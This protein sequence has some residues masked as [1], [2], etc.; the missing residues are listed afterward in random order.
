MFDNLI[1]HWV[2]DNAHKV[3]GWICTHLWG[4][5]K[6]EQILAG[7]HID[8]A[9]AQLAE[10]GAAELKK[11]AAPVEQAATATATAATAAAAAAVPP[12][13]PPAAAS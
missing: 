6:G 5:E 9:V 4:M 13:E 11:I 7:L 1:K 12:A 2:Q 8:T 3:L 10:A